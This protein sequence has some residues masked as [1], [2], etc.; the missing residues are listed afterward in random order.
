MKL[1]VAAL[2][3]AV[4]VG[5]IPLVAAQ[6]AV[7]ATPV[8]QE[9]RIVFPAS[10][11]QGALVFGKVPPGSQVRYRDRALR[12][13]GYGT[14][15]FANEMLKSHGESMEGKTVTVSG[16]G[17]VAIYAV[18]KAHQLGG[19][20]IGF[21]DSSGYV[22]DEA[23]VDLELLKQIKEVERGRVADYVARRPSAQLGRDGGIWDVP[24][25]VALPCATQNELHGDHAL[26]LIKN[27][28]RA[29]A[30]GAN[31]PTT[32]EGVSAFQEAGVLFGPAKAAN[33]GGVATSA[34]EMQQNAGRDAWDFE[35]TEQRLTEIMTGIHETV[36]ETAEEYGMPGDYV[37]GA[38]IAGFVKVADAMK[39]FGIV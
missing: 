10:V 15:V 25:D 24:A 13:T 26:T 9:D 1:A 38:N 7:P 30:E 32:P 29:V 36:A 19:K 23:G 20:V 5:W 12:T 37:A 33:A 28:V 22:V 31:M 39:A 6:D 35:Y 14:V 27:G 18:E 11:S 16:S 17:N 8:S 3:A 21:S 34:L 4:C 2:F